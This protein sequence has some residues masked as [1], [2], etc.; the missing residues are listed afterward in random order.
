MNSKKMK[1][2]GTVVYMDSLR[3]KAFR[4]GFKMPYE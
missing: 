3:R 1:S 4:K 2:G